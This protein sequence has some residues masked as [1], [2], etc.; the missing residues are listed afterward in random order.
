[1]ANHIV[2][3]TFEPIGKD[4]IHPL[5]KESPMTF[6]YAKKKPDEEVGKI[7]PGRELHTGFS[8]HFPIQSVIN[9]L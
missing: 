5:S 8:D 6:E 2:S 1:M 7:S 4:K 9:V 3:S